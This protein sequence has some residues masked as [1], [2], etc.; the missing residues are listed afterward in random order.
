MWENT[1]IQNYFHS[2]FGQCLD[3]RLAEH[4]SFILKNKQ[5]K[6]VK[7]IVSASCIKLWINGGSFKSTKMFTNFLCVFHPRLVTRNFRAPPRLVGAYISYRLYYPYSLK[8]FVTHILCSSNLAYMIP[9][10]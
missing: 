1:K 9:G 8:L 3:F 4:T 5:V 2:R 10:R 7:Q 6:F